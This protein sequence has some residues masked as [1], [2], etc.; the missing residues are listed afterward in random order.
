MEV[1]RILEMM[2]RIEI[3]EVTIFYIE[4]IYAILQ[5]AA[6]YNPSTFIGSHD[7]NP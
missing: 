3:T 4:N 6:K 7:E 2:H 1:E 5:R